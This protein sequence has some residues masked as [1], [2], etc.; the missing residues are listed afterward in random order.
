MGPSKRKTT[1]AKIIPL[2]QPDRE[3]WKQQNAEVLENVQDQALKEMIKMVLNLHELEHTGEWRQAHRRLD[4]SK[5]TFLDY[6]Q[7]YARWS[8]PEFRLL[9]EAVFENFDELK[10]KGLYSVLIR[11]RKEKDGK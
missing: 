9:E 11:L 2:D 8:L 4:F 5:S 1:M 3:H 7:L 10:R 6:L